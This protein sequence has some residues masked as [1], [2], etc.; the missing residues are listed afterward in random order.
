M[1]K[2]TY[3]AKEQAAMPGHKLAQQHV[4]LLFCSNATCDFKPKPLCI[5]QSAHPRAF[6]NVSMN[7]LPVIWHSNN[8]AWMT[9]AIFEEW[10]LHHFC[11]AVERYCRMKNISHKA[12]LFLDNCAGHPVNLNDLQDHVKVVFLPPRTSSQ[13]TKM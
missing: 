4:S 2:R 5:A 6:K 1:P 12:I 11:P 8:T 10:F 7:T 3:L 13:W 9:K